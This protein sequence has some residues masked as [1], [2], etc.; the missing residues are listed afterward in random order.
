[1]SGNKWTLSE[2]QQKKHVYNIILMQG[3]NHSDSLMKITKD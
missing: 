3:N 1:M 2:K